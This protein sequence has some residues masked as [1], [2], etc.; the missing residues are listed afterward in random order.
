MSLARY[1]AIPEGGN[2]KDLPDELLSPCWRDHR[3]GS[4]DVMGRLV[5]DK[6]AVTIRTEFWKPEKGRYL[7]PV[8]HRPITLFEGALLQ[9]FPE[10]YLWCGSKADIGRQIGNAV[11]IGLAAAIG[12]HILNHYFSS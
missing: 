9:G 7:H 3:G 8:A 1:R 4:G 11:P 6:P 12:Q 2:R 5:W 10:D